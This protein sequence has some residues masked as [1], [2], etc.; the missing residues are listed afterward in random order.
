MNNSACVLKMAR[1]ISALASEKD[2]APQHLAEAVQYCQL[3][4]QMPV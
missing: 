3:D 2:I 1:T 4:R